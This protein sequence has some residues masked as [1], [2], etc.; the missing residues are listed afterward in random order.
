MGHDV[1]DYRIPE[2]ALEEIEGDEYDLV[3]TDLNMPGLT[4]EDVIR[5]LSEQCP[6]LPV[7]LLTGLGTEQLD[8]GV[9]DSISAVL[10]KPI[11]LD[12]LRSS[13]S[14]VLALN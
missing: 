9:A 5:R 12:L 2:E 14:R 7:V 11:T 10:S 6:D 4:G 1:T 13:I 3:I 8:Q